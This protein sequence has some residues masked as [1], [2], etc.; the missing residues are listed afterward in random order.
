[1]KQRR[2]ASKVQHY[3]FYDELYL[4]NFR[5]VWPVTQDSLSRYIKDE[6]GN[7]E[8]FPESFGAKALII[9]SAKTPSHTCFVVALTRWNGTA[10]CHAMLSHECSHIAALLLEDRG[11]E[12]SP[13]NDES[14]TYLQ[15]YILRK[16]LNVLMPRS[17]Q[18]EVSDSV[19]P[20][21][22]SAAS[23]VKI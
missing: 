9:H 2:V 8:A 19:K 11:V 3:W 21:A 6:F 17:K 13:R 14:F 20:S 7:D 1:M 15:A 16:C 18:V 5:L 22:K 10:D 4:F 23:A 12:Y